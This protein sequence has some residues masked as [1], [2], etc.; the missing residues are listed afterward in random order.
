MI[1]P[2]SQIVG[3]Q[4]VLNVL[5]GERYGTTTERVPGMYWAIMGNRLHP[6]TRMFWI[7]CVK[8]LKGSGI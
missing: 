2:F 6:S 4:A 1:T 3:T 7:N 5:S 8:P